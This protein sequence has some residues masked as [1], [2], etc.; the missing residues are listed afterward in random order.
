MTSAQSD[1]QVALVT[2]A[3]GGIGEAVA[4]ALA[5][6]G[7]RVAAVD[8]DTDRLAEVRDQHD[9]VALHCY[10]GDVRDG[11]DIARVAA[12]V[13]E[14]LG[15]IDVLANVA[16]ILRPGP[17]VG[18]ADEDWSETFAVNATG[19]FNTSRAVAERMIERHRGCIIT[20]ASNAAVVPRMDMAA[21]GA[22]K[23]AAISFTK[24]LGLELAPHGIRCNVVAPGSTDTPMLT[25]L[26]NGDGDREATLS[27]APSR[28]RVGIP[29]NRIAQPDHVAEAVAFLASQ[30]AQHITM[31]SLC[32]DGGASLGA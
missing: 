3:A 6:S 8:V 13:E 4:V 9:G 14:E 16:G 2:G 31:Q 17:A 22:S 23:A 21:Y 32:V 5:A 20:V 26:W 11:D 10:P 12:R 29:L 28:F 7:A 30:Q 19:V 15:P 24:A 18:F 1:S 27:G 25:S